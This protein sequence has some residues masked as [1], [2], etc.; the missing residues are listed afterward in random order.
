MKYDIVY[1]KSKLI[2]LYKYQRKLIE[3]ENEAMLYFADGY[4]G[5]IRGHMP[6]GAWNDILYALEKYPEWKIS[7]EI[8]PESFDYLKNHDCGIYKRLSDFLQNDETAHRAEIISGSHSQPFCW[9]VNGESNIRQLLYG[10]KIHEN[11]FPECRIDTY[12]VQEPCFTSSL[13]Q[14]LSKMGYKRIVLKNPTAWGGYMTKMPG[15]II[16]LYSS[17]GSHLPAV[18]RYECEELFSC[19]AT[20]ASGYDS[21]IKDFADKCIKIGIRFPSG[22]CLQ[23]LGWSSKPIIKKGEIDVEYITWR[24]YFNRFLPESKINEDI[25]SNITFN[26]D[27]IRVSLPWGNQTFQSMLRKVRRTEN[28]ILQIEKLLSLSEN[29]TA[30][31]SNTSY[32][33]S[34]ILKQAWNLLM[35]AQHHDGYIC[36]TTKAWAYESGSFADTAAGLLDDIKENIIDS[37]ILSEVNSSGKS[38][39]NN[40]IWLKV[41]NTTGNVREDIAYINLGLDHGYND[42][43]VYDKND[44]KVNSQFRVIRKYESGCVGAVNLAF[45]TQFDGMGY[46]T[47]KVLL[48]SSEPEQDYEKADKKNLARIEG[49]LLIMENSETAIA[50]DLQ[51]GGAITEYTDKETGVDYVRGVKDLG[52]IRGYSIKE[53]RFISN[54]GTEV[55]CEIIENGAVYA[56]V[57]LSGH[58]SDAGF[59]TILTLESGKKLDV[60]ASIHFKEETYIGYPY[61]PS[62]EEKY[63]GT[64]RSSCR[65]DYKMSVYMPFT[66]NNITLYK[67]APYDICRS[68]CIDTRF[69]SWEDIK[70]SVINDYIDLYDDEKNT[71]IFVYCDCINGYSFYDNTFTL[72][73]AFGY[74]AN[75]WWGCQ[76]LEGISRIKYSL[77]PH[78]G[79]FAHASLN[80]A[81]NKIRE[82][83]ISF[84]IPYEPDEKS[85]YMIKINNNNVEL[86]TVYKDN[87]NYIA[88]LFNAS[89]KHEN[90]DYTCNINFFK[91]SVTDLN[92]NSLNSDK[93]L[94]KPMEIRTLI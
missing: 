83:L 56:K 63:H 74:H 90:P 50:F 72:T 23:D 24:E 75:F 29:Q 6:V 79:N 71:G 93:N 55:K 66:E 13:P 49:S 1:I 48:K 92:G 58:I 69:D 57:K 94:M 16:N 8:E 5:G 70:H 78:V 39:K 32:K 43:E 15:G 45:E 65:E 30:E 11:H 36:A 21:R 27:D 42:I 77:L 7:L 46:E 82:P 19:S 51:N 81:E 64:K 53:D 91:N 20:E 25:I 62:E 37:Y 52:S 12:A 2:L 4:H 31:N 47:Y 59:I 84:R 14:I 26:Q 76:P 28:Y 86:V 3:Q 17:D 44:R 33:N 61:T 60:E 80:S 18:T 10:R 67:S 73:L 88:R 34:S 85:K 38:Q 87:G 54:A 22:M 41:F 40:E 68:S 89:D 35:K 9:A